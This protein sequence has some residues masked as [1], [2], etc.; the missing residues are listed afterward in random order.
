MDESYVLSKFDD[1]LRSGRVLYDEKQEVVRRL[2]EQLEVG[3]PIVLVLQLSQAFSGRGKAKMR[4]LSTGDLKKNLL[5]FHFIV[6]TAL[7]MKP[8][9]PGS[10]N[11]GKGS[12]ASSTDT[13]GSD[14][15]TEGF[16]ISEMNGGSHLLVANKFSYGRPHLLL[17]TRDASQRQYEP[18]DQRDIDAMWAALTS[19]A[20]HDYMAF[21]NCGRDAGCSRLHKHMQLVPKPAHS[22]ADFLDNNDNGD[23]NWTE[24][25]A[26]K[27]P[28]QWFHRRFDVG[29]AGHVGSAE[30][31]MRTYSTLLEH[32]AAIQPN[33]AKQV[34]SAGAAGATCAHNVI[35][36][37]RGIIVI[38]R[39]R[40][41]VEP[42]GGANA[43]GMLGVIAVASKKEVD[44]WV[45]L[46]LTRAL[47]ELGVA[48]Y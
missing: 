36:T 9:R 28:F 15:S 41:S 47:A 29:A 45:Q 17:L 6:S 23:N 43:L 42:A 44:D 20:K 5:Q 37:R 21:Y 7:A 14:I 30:E 22:F 4:I 2:D 24:S 32:A 11:E 34:Q 18:L 48:R 40:A 46:G 27:V 16:V 10:D 3:N 39:R 8:L 12:G 31:V 35:L 38:P 33:I 1:L 13:E 26:P 25:V 19:A